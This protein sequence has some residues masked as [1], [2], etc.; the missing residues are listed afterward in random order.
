MNQE[1][2]GKFI[3]S[4]RKDK[5]LT[6]MQLAE[7]LNISNRAVSKWETGKSIPDVSIMLE[8]CEILGITVNELLSGERITTMEDYQK[9]AEQNM[10]DL[11][12]KKAQAQKSLFRVNLIWSVIAVLLTPAHLAINYYF[13]DNNGTGIGELILLIGFVMFAVY[14][15]RYYEIKLK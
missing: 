15:F 8:L 14:F 6:Q 11:Q 9:N 1:M 2:V 10:V 4:C 5:G 13:P 7:K 12:G 3:S